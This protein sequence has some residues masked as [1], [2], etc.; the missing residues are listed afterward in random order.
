MSSQSEETREEAAVGTRMLVDFGLSAGVRSSLGHV[1][2]RVPGE[3]NHFVVKGRGYRLDALNRIRAQDLVV[4][5]LEGNLVDGPPNIVPCFEV[6]IHSC[7]YKARPD[8]NSVVHVHPTYTV[9]LS[10]LGKDFRPMCAEGSRL[11]IDP[12]PVYPRQ[13]IITTDEEGTEV[14]RLLGHGSVE[15]LFGHGAVTAG[16]SMERS[17]SSMIQ[18][19]HQAHMNYLAYCAAGRG[20]PSVPRELVLEGAASAGSQFDLPHFKQS[21]EKAGAPLYGGVWQAWYEDAAAQL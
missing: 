2:V 6:K 14:A 11:V 17:V 4:C 15:L 18:L 13:K 7:I 21:I 1:S 16:D 9:L 10:V 19:E 12:I 20:H 5:D 3:P 8:V